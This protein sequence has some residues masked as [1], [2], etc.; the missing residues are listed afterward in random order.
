MAYSKGKDL[1]IPKVNPSPPPP[2]P[3]ASLQV[4]RQPH[5]PPNTSLAP[6]PPQDARSAHGGGGARAGPRVRRVHRGKTE[7]AG[8]RPCVV[9]AGVLQELPNAMVPVA[10]WAAKILKRVCELAQEFRV[11]LRI[12]L[13]ADTRGARVC[14][15][16]KKKTSKS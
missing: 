7:G 14:C 15:L 12:A 8:G 13:R 3:L 6:T 4:A 5:P 11:E 9:G 10:A 2:T 1:G 16:T